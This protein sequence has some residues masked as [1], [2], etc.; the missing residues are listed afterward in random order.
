MIMFN[1]AFNSFSEAILME[2][3]NGHSHGIYVW[4]VL[5]IVFLC[6]FIAFFFYKNKIKKITKKFK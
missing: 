4:S 2:S 1:F 3:Q 6:I 5:L